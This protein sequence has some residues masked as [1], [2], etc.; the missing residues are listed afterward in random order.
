MTGRLGEGQLRRELQMA[1][2]L[3]PVCDDQVQSGVSGDVLAGERA[4][5]GEGGYEQLHIRVRI[6]GDE[7]EYARPGEACGA[8]RGGD[9]QGGV[10]AR[11]I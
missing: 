1:A 11:A 2:A 4:E 7:A 10:V 3:R 5:W 9:G 6:G 8:E